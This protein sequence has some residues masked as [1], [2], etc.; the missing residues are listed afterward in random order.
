[1]R[2]V[3]GLSGGVDS[4]M[5]AALLKEARHTVIGAIMRIWDGRPMADEPARHGCY[6]PGEVEDVAEAERIAAH[7]GIPLHIIDLSREYTALV[8]EQCTRQYLAGLTPNPCVHC[9]R[10]MKFELIPAR[11]REMGVAFDG[12]ATG[13]YAIVDH[14]EASGRYRL[15]RGIDRDKDQSYFLYQLTQKQLARTL[16]PLGPYT[17]AEIR[18]RAAALGLPVAERPESQ[19]FV[20]GGYASIF[21]N[22]SQPGPIL[23]EDGRR[24]GEHRGIEHYTVGQRRG[25][26]IAHTEPLYVL[27]IDDVRNAVIV[28]PGDRLL[29]SELEAGE[30]NWI[31]IP[32]L[33]E[34]LRVQARIR[35]RHAPAAATVAPAGGG[36]AAVHFD[37]PQRAIAPGQA[38]VFYDGD[39]VVGGGIIAKLPPTP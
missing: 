17:K 21:S 3:V 28:G 34:Q 13:H 22:P 12:F 18:R 27:A 15:R 26:D 31:A 6:G 39:L 32:E 9:N 8:L 5:A 29:R 36:R 19:D 4:A 38:V 24:L 37:E 10:L 23:G 20:S 16:L 30:L 35:Y 7:L 11:L 33:R 2:V 25:L 14:D 1:M